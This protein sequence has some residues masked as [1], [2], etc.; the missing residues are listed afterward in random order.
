[1]FLP[2]IVLF[3]NVRS[4][5]SM[6]R[7]PALSV[8]VSSLILLSSLGIRELTLQTFYRLC[9]S[10]CD[11]QLSEIGLVLEFLLPFANYNLTISNYNSSTN[12]IH[13]LFD[14]FVVPLSEVKTK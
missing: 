8:N 10:D 1:M 6:T 14:K 12:D 7:T 4:L 13:F 3:A 5:S 9:F 2:R 11:D